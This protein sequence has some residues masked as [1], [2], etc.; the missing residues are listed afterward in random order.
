MD[1]WW[2]VPAWQKSSQKAQW[3][4]EDE[5]VDWRRGEN[6]QA[7]LLPSCRVQYTIKINGQNW[8]LYNHPLLGVMKLMMIFLYI[9]SALYFLFL[10][11]FL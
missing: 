6:G 1:M 9:W 10:F 11:L 8:F 7:C 2:D 4:E 3:W 5:E